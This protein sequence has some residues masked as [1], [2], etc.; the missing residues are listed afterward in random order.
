MQTNLLLKD[1]HAWKRHVWVSF[2]MAP[3]W[4]ARSW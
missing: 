4:T 2:G 3:I 1:T